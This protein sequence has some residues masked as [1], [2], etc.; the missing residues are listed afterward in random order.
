[1]NSYCQKSISRIQFEKEL[2]LIQQ[3]NKLFVN[4]FLKDVLLLEQSVHFLS[5]PYP[6][7]IASLK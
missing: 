1:M 5:L 7:K 3:G 6:Y 4:A 2:K